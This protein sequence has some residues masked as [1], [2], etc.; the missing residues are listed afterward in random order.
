MIKYTLRQKIQIKLAMYIMPIITKLLISHK[1]NTFVWRLLGVKI[2]KN[3]IIRTGTFINAPFMVKIGDNSIIHGHLKSRGGI[4]IGSN[5]EF[6]ENVT[7]STQSHNIN[8]KY[9]EPIYKPVI[10][11]DNCWISLNA[12]ILQGVTLKKGTIVAAGAVVT[13]STKECG[14][15]AGIPAKKIK[16]RVC[17]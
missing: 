12:I 16:D 6:V 7:I 10:I 14:A 4:V 8:S 1:L 13:K 2:G 15:Y 17:K 11:E 3:S 9:F 5:V